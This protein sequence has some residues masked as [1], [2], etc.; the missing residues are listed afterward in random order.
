M[1][2]LYRSLYAK[3]ATGLSPEDIDKKIQYALEQ[4]P[5]GFINSFYEKYTGAGPSAEQANYIASKIET[6]LKDRYDKSEEQMPED[7]S[8]FENTGKWLKGVAQN[9]FGGWSDATDN[10]LGEDVT[11]DDVMGEDFSKTIEKNT[12]QIQ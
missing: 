7:V 5:A 10:M 12:F 4:D 2:E 1:E 11:E 8:M 3:Y 6:D 9:W